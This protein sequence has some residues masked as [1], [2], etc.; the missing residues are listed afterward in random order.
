MRPP[1]RPALAALALTLLTILSACD[2]DRAADD[3]RSARGRD[4]VAAAALLTSADLGGSF[5]RSEDDDPGLREDTGVGCLADQ[6]DAT[7]PLERAEVAFDEGDDGLPAIFNTVETYRDPA[8]VRRLMQRLRS[9]LAE[10]GDRSESHVGLELELDIDAGDLP[11][12]PGVDDQIAVDARGSVGAG[13]ASLDVDL[14]LVVASVGR[15]V[16]VVGVVALDG[17]AGSLLAPYA[18]L[19][20]QHLVDATE[21]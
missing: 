19:A 17:D 18:L 1:A 8:D 10:C 2:G 15:R 4:H 21:L 3:V 12:P 11:V 13:G 9:D 14:S 16:T 6:L 20:E 7:N 5:S